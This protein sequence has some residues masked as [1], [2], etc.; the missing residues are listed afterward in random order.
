MKGLDYIIAMR[1]K[2][3]KPVSVTLSHKRYDREL[4]PT[5]PQYEPSDFPETSDLRALVGL[6][7]TVMGSDAELVG[8]WC[9]ASMNAGAATVMS[10]VMAGG[11]E[12]STWVEYRLYGVDQ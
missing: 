12:D 11:S 5:W 2:G 7:V 8:R 4:T 1:H 10:C 3:F 9:K 6:F